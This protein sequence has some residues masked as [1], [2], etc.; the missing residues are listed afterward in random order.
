MYTK[1]ITNHFCFY[2]VSF[3]SRKVRDIANTLIRVRKLLLGAWDAYIAIEEI[4]N[5]AR[6]SSSQF[7]F[8][9]RP[10]LALPSSTPPPSTTHLYK[11]HTGKSLSDEKPAAG[12]IISVS[13]GKSGAGV[14]CWRGRRNLEHIETAKRSGYV[15]DHFLS[16][17]LCFAWERKIG[18]TP[19][20]K[21]KKKKRKRGRVSFCWYISFFYI[22]RPQ[23]ALK[24]TGRRASMYHPKFCSRLKTQSPRW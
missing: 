24:R 6:I 12:F 15:S 4:K 1:N 5:F 9:L 21:K 7:L 11:T 14:F 10:A 18:T 16:R 20:P 8:L 22:H 19:L 17:C 13:I 3:Y 23:H 2:F